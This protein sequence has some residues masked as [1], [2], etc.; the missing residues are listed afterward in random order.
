MPPP[1]PRQAIPGV[2][3]IVA[4]SSGKGGVGKSTV[5]GKRGGWWRSRSRES[6]PPLFFLLNLL[7]KKKIA[8]NLAVA[9]ARSGLSASIL[10][11][12]VH[13]PSV[14]RLL[15][16]AGR[17]AEVDPASGKLVPLLCRGGLVR[18]LSMGNLVDE[19]AAAV[20]RGPM[21]MSAL[22]TLTRQADWRGTD[23]LV[24][25]MPPGTGDAHLSVAQRLPLA[26]ALAVTTPQRVAVD[27]VRRG[28]R[29][30]S[31]A[32]VR[33]LGVVENMSGF[34]CSGCGRVEDVFGGGGGG[35]EGEDE[36]ESE[37]S[38]LLGAPL[39]ARVPLS[40]ALRVSCDEGRPLVLLSEEE[41]GL[42]RGARASAEALER[43]AAR[44]REILG[45]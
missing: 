27:D 32:G 42:D 29:G 6:P 21:V 39:L 33:L 37:A 16:L 36:G 9:L 43:V 40:R 34:A 17:R 13:G 38:R 25:D 31:A 22:E 24:L 11:A 18:S 10:D 19:G 41:R 28:A 45:V 2:A 26:G 12:D 7:F 1:P 3:H 23:V 44:V 4:V 5:A 15:G 8:V 20:W 35:G 14:P 30:W